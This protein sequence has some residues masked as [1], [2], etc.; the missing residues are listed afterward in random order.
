VRHD[1]L[2]CKAKNEI[3]ELAASARAL[4]IFI[5][6]KAGKP[7]S[8]VILIAKAVYQRGLNKLL[9][10][11]LRAQ[12]CDIGP[13]PGLAFFNENEGAS[14]ILLVKLLRFLFQKRFQGRVD[15][16]AQL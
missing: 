3:D 15:L 1:V 10:G 5:D 2:D 14:E 7:D 13:D 11:H 12:S 6:G 4:N 16:I 9:N 8:R